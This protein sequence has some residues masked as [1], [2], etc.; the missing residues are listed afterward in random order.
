MLQVLNSLSF[1]YCT[2][3]AQ[4]PGHSAGREESRYLEA[5]EYLVGE[6]QPQLLLVRN[7]HVVRRQHLPRAMSVRPR[8]A[9]GFLCIVDQRVRQVWPGC[10]ENTVSFCY[11]P[12]Q[13]CLTSLTISSSGRASRTKVFQRRVV[14]PTTMTLSPGLHLS[15]KS[16]SS[17][18]HIDR[19]ILPTPS[20]WTCQ[21]NAHLK[22]AFEAV[23]CLLRTARHPAAEVFCIVP[24]P[25]S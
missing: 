23:A 24:P 3:S 7:H 10:K 19:G 13:K 22:S 9:C 20:F 11:G 21:R 16:F 25:G 15:T 8:P 2:D 4:Y 18:T 17:T 14:T 1:S 5:P 6:F 12:T